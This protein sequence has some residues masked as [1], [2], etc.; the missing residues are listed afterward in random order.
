M[1][2]TKEER[3][4]FDSLEKMFDS[5][6]WRQIVSD[7]QVQIY[8]L[9]ADALDTR[10][11]PTWDHVNVAKGRALQLNELVLMEDMVRTMRAQKEDES[12]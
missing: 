4:Y 9:Q 2:L 1:A 12:E 6:G 3:Q 11:C 5:D 8:Q 7:A 10:V